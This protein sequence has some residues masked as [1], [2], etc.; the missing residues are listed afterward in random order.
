MAIFQI[1]VEGRA[2]HAG[3]AHEHGANAIVQLADV[4]KQIDGLTDYSRNL[5]FNVGTVSG[6]TVFNRVP[7]SASATVEMRAFDLEVYEQ[8]IADVLALNNFVSVGSAS[9]DFTCRV[10]AQLERQSFPW[11][12]NEQ[13][14]GLYRV[15]HDTALALGFETT[16]QARAGLSDGNMLWDKMPALDGLGPAGGNAHCSERS[17]DGS[18]DQEYVLRSSFV[19]KALL[20]TLAI[21][22]LAGGSE[23]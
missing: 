16:P 4:I 12:R 22:R 5:T 8:G 3:S 7:H 9:G 15:W 20:N 18:K 14:D 23:W 6:G 13:T 19:P 11:A 2:A 17:P 21:L 10:N 1:D